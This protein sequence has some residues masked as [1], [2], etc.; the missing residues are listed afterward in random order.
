ML[1][2]TVSSFQ[3]ARFPLKMA[4]S[5][6]SCERVCILLLTVSLAA[7]IRSQVKYNASIR[8]VLSTFNSYSYNFNEIEE[9]T[10]TCGLLIYP[11]SKFVTQKIRYQ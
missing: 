11:P 2:L 10:L 5:R 8:R 9:K 4:L 3:M 7:D 1:T 6:C